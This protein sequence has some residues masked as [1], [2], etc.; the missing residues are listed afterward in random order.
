MKL[1]SYW[2][3]KAK[4]EV[5]GIDY[6]DVNN[7]GLNEV[8]FATW[9]GKIYF[10]NALNGQIIQKFPRKGHL[11]GV[12]ENILILKRNGERNSL[13][14]S[15][16]RRLIGVDFE[17]DNPIWESPMDSWIVK[18]FKADI[19]EDGEEE[20]VG[21]TTSGTRFGVDWGGEK[22]WVVEG[23]KALTPNKMAVGDINFDGSTEIISVGKKPNLLEIMGSD[24][25]VLHNIKLRDQIE[26]IAVGDIKPGL[27]GILVVGTKSSIYFWGEDFKKMYKLRGEQL[28]YQITIADV[29]SDGINEILVCDWVKNR[30]SV[31]S[32][33]EDLDIRK[34]DEVNVEGNPIYA[35]V[36]NL[37]NGD[38]TNKIAIAVKSTEIGIEDK[39]QIGSGRKKIELPWS[40]SIHPPVVGDVFGLGSQELLLRTNREELSLIISVPKIAVPK[41]VKEKESFTVTTWTPADYVFEASRIFKH[42]EKTSSTR[43]RFGEVGYVTTNTY[44]LKTNRPGRGKIK[45]TK[46]GK[47]ETITKTIYIFS[48]SRIVSDSTPLFVGK[49]DKI[50]LEYE[51]E[52]KEIRS[53]TKKVETKLIK[54]NNEQYLLF[55]SYLEGLITV[56]LEIIIGEKNEDRKHKK[57]NLKIYVINPLSVELKIKNIMLNGDEIELKIN[58]KSSLSLNASLEIEEPIDSIPINIKIP[59]RRSKKISFKVDYSPKDLIED[60]NTVVLITYKGVRI[61]KLTVPFKTKIINKSKLRELIKEIKTTSRSKK[62]IIES[63]KD[64]L[65]LNEAEIE[66]ILERIRI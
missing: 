22:L 23:S 36:I 64:V 65:S 7:D 3:V 47:G 26:S 16:N 39:L 2:T 20:I 32:I 19:D 42:V 60:L 21:F 55:S 35:G 58:N 1:I 14:S 48:D 51:T 66:E 31:L 56:P 45:L 34:V 9:E 63:L 49:E 17:S 38:G 59:P 15:F 12:A 6:G 54:D 25:G 40:A 27:E 13:V 57:M 33:N 30:V 50:K 18:L 46:R 8:I 10:V 29:N 37:Q 61:H 4:D 24:G 11:E 5:R 43:K 53:L 52:V 62:K 44:K 28:P 41:V